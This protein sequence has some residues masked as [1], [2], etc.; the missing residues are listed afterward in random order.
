MMIEQVCTVLI[1]C[2]VGLNPYSNGMIIERETVVKK[3]KFLAVLFLIL[4]E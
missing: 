4:M 2:T 3:A 1:P